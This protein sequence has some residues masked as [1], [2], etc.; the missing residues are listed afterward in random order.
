M[1]KQTP[2]ALLRQ[3]FFVGIIFIR[4]ICEWARRDEVSIGFDCHDKKYLKIAMP[5]SVESLCMILLASADMIMVG[6]LGAEAIA[7][8]SIFMQPRLVLFCFSRSAAAA[9]TLLASRYAGRGERIEAAD[10]LKQMLGVSCAFFMVLHLVFWYFLQDILTLMGAEPDYISLAMEYANIATAAAYISSVTYVLQAIQLGFGKTTEIMRT[11]LIGNGV[12]IAA[13]FFL[14][15]GIGPFPAMGVAGAALGTVI[16]TLS[17]IAMT[18]AEMKKEEFFAWRKECKWFPT[19]ERWKSFMPVYL[20]VFS[21]QGCERAGMV[22]F[23]RIAAGLGTVPF[24]V[25]SICM[26]IADIYYDFAQGPGKASMVLA[27]QACG[28]KDVNEWHTYRNVGVKLTFIFS[29]ISCVLTILFHDELYLLFM[30]DGRG[31]ELAAVVLI[32]RA[33]VSFPEGHAITCASILRASGQTASVA[34]YSFISVTILRP[35][36]T[37][38][39]TY[40]LGFGLIGCWMALAID[41]TTRGTCATVLL[42]RLHN[43]IHEEMEK[44]LG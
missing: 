40:P 21:E 4:S 44:K 41:Q 1:I 17:T 2:A 5:A 43:R 32:I 20:S 33:F 9:L 7:A 38:L 35:I 10:L 39:L 27:G 18:C 30:P 28:K 26:N 15:F 42:R 12:N 24:A 19:R 22:L 11:N 37:W 16:G 6:T 8:V 3:E 29:A 34:A 23:T 25:H 36:I 13:N 14:I 31:I